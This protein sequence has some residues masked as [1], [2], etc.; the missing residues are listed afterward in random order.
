MIV[1]AFRCHEI[2]DGRAFLAED[3]SVA[4]DG[5]YKL[6]MIPLALAGS[7]SIGLS[8]TSFSLTLIGGLATATLLTLLVVPAFYTIFDDLRL[9]MAA[10]IS[11]KRA[12]QEAPAVPAEVSPAT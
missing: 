8:Y 3:F 12:A 6:T 1:K 11:P 9:I 10:A 5:N 2:A 4:C 7:N